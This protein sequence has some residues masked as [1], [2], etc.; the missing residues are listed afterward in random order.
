MAL[1]NLEPL[2][3]LD[4]E[5]RLNELLS[6]R[7][8]VLLKHSTLCGLSWAA[9]DELMAWHGRVRRADVPAYILTV[10]T[11]RA[12]SDEVSCRTGVAHASP[13]VLVLRHGKVVATASHRAV[14]AS[15]LAGQLALH[16]DS[17]ALA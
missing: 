13:Q 11:H 9:H 7:L 17:L 10:G 3:S 2:R 15:F 1:R 16:N 6:L 5:E 12:L 8:A 4:S 14:T